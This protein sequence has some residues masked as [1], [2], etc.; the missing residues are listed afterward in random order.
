MLQAPADGD[1]NQ[2][3]IEI[4]KCKSLN[5]ITGKGYSDFDLQKYTKNRGCDRYY[6]SITALTLL[7]VPMYP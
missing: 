3:M 6:E 7:T 1:Y 2:N 4:K 5:H